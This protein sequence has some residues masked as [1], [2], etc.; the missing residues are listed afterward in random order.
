MSYVNRETAKQA[1]V[2]SRAETINQLDQLTR[3]H[4]KHVISDEIYERE[5]KKLVSLLN[6]DAGEA[7]LDD[8]KSECNF[9]VQIQ[10]HARGVGKVF[11]FVDGHRMP[12]EL[13]NGNYDFY[14]PDGSHK[15]YFSNGA[16]YS[17]R[18]SITIDADTQYKVLLK[19]GLIA[20][21]ADVQKVQ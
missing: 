11:L 20:I 19:I 5:S 8:G 13:V 14:I 9:H 6:Q 17:R 3:L 16:S 10:S 2:S 15:I 1:A 18:T 21:N 7:D 4:D 12:P